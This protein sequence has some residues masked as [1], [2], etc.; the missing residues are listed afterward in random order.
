MINKR[1]PNTRG[2]LDIALG[3]K[4]CHWLVTG[5][6]FSPGT[7]VSSANKTDHDD[8]TELLYFG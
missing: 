8:Y 5:Q 6:W 3:D 2:V 1:R 4:V 7:S